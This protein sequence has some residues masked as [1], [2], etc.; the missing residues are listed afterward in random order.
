MPGPSLSSISFRHKGPLMPRVPPGHHT[1]GRSRRYLGPGSYLTLCISGVP[2]RPAIERQ[3]EHQTAIALRI[4]RR[5]TFKRRGLRSRKG[6]PR[7]SVQ[8]LP[9]LHPP[10]LYLQGSARLCHQTHRPVSGT[11]SSNFL[12]RG[13]CSSAP[14]LPVSHLPGTQGCSSLSSHLLLKDGLTPKPTSISPLPQ[15]LHHGSPVVKMGS[16]LL[17]P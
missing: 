11:A 14:I 6:H 13:P 3:H 5:H 17:H 1:W 10:C 9:R 12:A 7:A 4:R 8:R 16:T 15:R 2:R